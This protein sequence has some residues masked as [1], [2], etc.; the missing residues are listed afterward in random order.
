MSP[1]ILFQKMYGE[2]KPLY[3][4]K[5]HGANRTDKIF[6]KKLYQLDS[7]LRDLNDDQLSAIHETLATFV[8]KNCLGTY[9]AKNQVKWNRIAV[10]PN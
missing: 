3:L 9:V 2:F 5:E 10:K 4:P 7:E 6:V 1:V 8:R